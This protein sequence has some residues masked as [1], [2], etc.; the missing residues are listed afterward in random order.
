MEELKRRN[1]DLLSIVIPCFNAERYISL[2]LKSIFAQ[3]ISPLEVI[4][5][6]DGSTDSSAKEVEA[7][8]D[9]VRLVSAPHRGISASRNEG[10]ALSN[11]RLLAFLDADD[12]WPLGSLRVR[13]EALKGG[14]ECVF[15]AVENFVSDDA[16][17]P[18]RASLHFTQN[19]LVGRMPGTMLIQRAAFDRVGLFDTSFE[20]G[21]MFD[22]ISRAEQVGLKFAQVKEIVLRRR[23]HNNNTTLKY[24]QNKHDYLRALRAAIAR[25][26]ALEEN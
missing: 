10:I 4:V 19:A 20:I 21:E 2:A 11:G 6:D 8:G 5:V 12:L 3:G 17:F 15:G 7:F 14:I 16:E 18:H 22:W 24:R 1:S 23:I 25:K 26:N 9:S 13:L